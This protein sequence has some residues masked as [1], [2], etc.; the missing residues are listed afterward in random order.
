MKP[1]KTQIA[2]VLLSL[3]GF[4]KSSLWGLSKLENKLGRLSWDRYLSISAWLDTDSTFIAFSLIHL[5][6]KP[7]NN[8]QKTAE[9]E[10]PLWAALCFTLTCQLLSLHPSTWPSDKGVSTEWEV[11]PSQSLQTL[12][13]SQT[14]EKQE[15]VFSFLLLVG[16]KRTAYTNNTVQETFRD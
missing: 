3:R 4:Q 13:K 11:C 12:G 10:H 5:G 2:Y 6:N 9:Q 1:A 7:L 14:V 15:P 8:P 16:G